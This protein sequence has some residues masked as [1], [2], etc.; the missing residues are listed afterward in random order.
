M[1]KHVFEDFDDDEERPGEWHNGV[2]IPGEDFPVA[3]IAEED[4]AVLATMN[5]LEQL[6]CKSS[7]PYGPLG[8]LG[9][10]GL[11]LTQAVKDSPAVLKGRVHP[12]VRVFREQKKAIL[13]KILPEVGLVVRN[14]AF[15]LRADDEVRKDRVHYGKPGI[16]EWYG[17]NLTQA[18]RHRLYFSKLVPALFYA[19]DEFDYRLGTIGGGLQIAK[20]EAKKKRG[21]IDIHALKAAESTIDDLKGEVKDRLSELIEGFKGLC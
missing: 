13:E 12:S 19:M 16:S 4:S 21:S 20:S 18:E 6:I 9:H 7:G 1:A 3:G 17:R 10:I 11:K 8:A 2:Y 5:S 14:T 15:T